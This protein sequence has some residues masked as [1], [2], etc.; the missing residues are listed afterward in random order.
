MS[1]TK[2][3]LILAAGNG[4]RLAARSGELPKPLV[5][6]HGKPL[7]EHVVRGA[8]QAGIE[9]FVIV[10]GYHGHLIQ[11]WWKNSPVRDLPVTWVENPE[12]LKNNGVSV[13]RAKPEIHEPFLL[14]MSDHIFEPQTARALLHQPVQEGEVILGVDKN[15][16]S[17]FDLD[18]AT[19]VRMD[20]D[21]IVNIG[22]DLA[23]YDALDTGM[24]HCTPALFQ[25][26]ESA[27][28][29]WNCSLS[30]GLRLLAGAGKFKGFD[31]GD[32]HWQDCD[33]PEALDYAN[34][35]FPAVRVPTSALPQVIYA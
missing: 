8:H 19:K 20:G 23:L 6:L 32:A 12:Y 31:I 9:R 5:R 16:D 26:L 29:N 27:M 2:V 28:F 18:D 14:L 13:L 25:A 21:R 11:Q 4:S 3:A 33:T 10:V 17:V 22:K 34:D 1:N 24:F 30:D 35:I 7:L 15:I